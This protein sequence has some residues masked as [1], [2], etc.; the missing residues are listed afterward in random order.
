[1]LDEV[2][3]LS[4][5]LQ[6]RLLDLVK[7]GRYHREFE[8]RERVAQVNVIVITDGNLLAEV[9]A[10]RFRHDLYHKLGRLDLVLP[11]LRERP[12]DVPGAARWMA[13]RV[14][15][16]RGLPATVE[17][18]GDAAA[19]AGSI[20]IRKD[21]IEA[22]RQHRWPGNFRELEIVVERALMLYGD[23]TQVTAAD[24]HKALAE[25]T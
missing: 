15:I 5:A 11:P 17:L 16:D 9:Q 19:A 4:P 24:V 10:G 18:E 23:G 7:R 25:P 6:R 20:L 12:E 14:R 3:G 21:A 13:N 8:D 22:L 1:M 2:I